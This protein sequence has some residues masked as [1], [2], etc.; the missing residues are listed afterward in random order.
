MTNC[1]LLACCLSKNLT[2][3]LGAVPCSV[4]SGDSHRWQSLP[5]FRLRL[6]SLISRNLQLVRESFRWIDFDFRRHRWRFGFRNQT[7]VDLVRTIWLWK[8]ESSRPNNGKLAPFTLKNY[9]TQTTGGCEAHG[10]EV[11][12]VLAAACSRESCHWRK[13]Q[14]SSS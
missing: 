14:P 10:V 7:Q 5:D 13:C 9:L 2:I 1:W 3:N 11:L 8:L 12:K 4:L 6:V